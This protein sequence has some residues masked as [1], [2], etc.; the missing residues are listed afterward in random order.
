MDSTTS[1]KTG[2]AIYMDA[3][4]IDQKM[5]FTCKFE[6]TDKEDLNV[7]IITDEVERPVVDEKTN[8]TTSKVREDK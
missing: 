6:Y 7:Y 1:Y 2:K 5:V 3:D 4:E 8:K